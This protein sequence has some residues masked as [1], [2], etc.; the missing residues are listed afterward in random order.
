MAAI[1]ALRLA[2]PGSSILATMRTTRILKAVNW[3]YALGEVFLIV[4]GILIA[5]AISDWNDRRLDRQQEKAML[6]EVRGAMEMDLAALESKLEEARLAIGQMEDLLEKLESPPAHT[7]EMDGLFGSVYGLR[8]A[9]LSSAAYESLKSLGLQSVSNL[10]L[11]TLI[12]RVFDHHYVR[13][14]IE[15]EIEQEITLTVMRPY[16]LSHFVDLQ[17]WKNATPLD[18]EAVVSDPYFRNILH[19]RITAF[20]SNQL[21]SYP[22][23]IADIRSAISMID[24]EL[25]R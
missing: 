24:E 19:Y 6:R 10:E 23:V 11:R 21:D 8:R 7:P 9:N 5:L 13:L 14:G 16:F 4:V 17:F 12:A 18:Y 2:S 15:H 1:D 3:R 20:K 22:L 25:E